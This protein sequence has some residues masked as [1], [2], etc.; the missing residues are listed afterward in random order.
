M[1]AD[2]KLERVVR[3][4]AAALKV[5][6]GTINALAGRANPVDPPDAP[7]QKRQDYRP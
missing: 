3:A 2:G 5:F 6:F 7:P 4:G 1:G